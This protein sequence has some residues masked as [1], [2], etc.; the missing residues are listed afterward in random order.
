MKRLHA[1]GLILAVWLTGAAAPAADVVESA[2]E[3][4]RDLID[5]GRVTIGTL[6]ER[7]RESVQALTERG[8]E[9]AEALA[10]RGGQTLAGVPR[11]GRRTFQFISATR[12]WLTCAHTKD[13]ACTGG[14]CTEPCY[15][16]AFWEHRTGLFGDF[17]YL[18]PR[19]QDL[20]YATPVDGAIAGAVPQ[21]RRRMIDP[22]YEPGFRVGGR[23]AIDECSSI[24]AAFWYY[25][26]GDTDSFNVPGGPPWIRAELTHPNTLSVAADSLS[27]AAAQQWKFQMADLT[28]ERVI[29]YSDVHVIN[30]VVG[31]RYG[32]LEQD[33]WARYFINGSTTVTTDID[34]DGAG[35]R[36]GLDGERY[37]GRGFFTYGNAFATFLAGEF[38]ADYLQTNVFVGQQA[39]DGIVD[40]RIVPQLELE[41]GL[42]WQNCCGNLRVKAGYYIGAWF[43]AITT[44]EF[45]EGVQVNSLADVNDTLVFEGMVIRAEARF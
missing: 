10:E 21:G 35:P 39:R 12:D 27:T 25:Y 6:A 24:A 41:L 14:E 20:P 8:V 17:L 5:S 22:G 44:S 28:Y 19:E 11:A 1:T 16:P 31:A 32:H 18:N 4:T 3:R 42:G 43:N 29:S 33:M 36:L 30:A 13:G 7:S 37:L 23:V 9:S 34:F 26:G 38:R 2:R 45:I 15:T 40:E